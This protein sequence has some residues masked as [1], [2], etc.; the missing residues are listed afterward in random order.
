MSQHVSLGIL[1]NLVSFQLRRAHNV[2]FRKLDQELGARGATTAMLGTLEVVARNEGISQGVVAEVLALN[3]STMVPIIEKL[4]E[5][6]WLL[7]ERTQHDRRTVLLS[8]TEPG[9]QE[10]TRLREIVGTHEKRLRQHLD[11]ESAE[12]LLRGLRQ[13]GDE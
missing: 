10:L 13:L 12:A 3:R 9:R 8:I 4:C 11:I 5:R 7:R 2:A 6:G 1:E